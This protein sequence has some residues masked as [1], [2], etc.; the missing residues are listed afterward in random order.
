MWDTCYYLHF[1]DKKINAQGQIH[2]SLSGR[3]GPETTICLS[4]NPAFSEKHSPFCPQAAWS[5]LSPLYAF[6]PLL[7]VKVIL[8]KHY[9]LCGQPLHFIRRSQVCDGQQDCA[10]G[11]D[12]Q[13]CVQNSPDGPPVAGESRAWGAR[14][15]GTA[16]SQLRFPWSTA[17]HLPPDLSV[18][19]PITRFLRIGPHLVH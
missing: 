2:Q 10:S 1:T 9:F 15:V 13:H 3:T 18:S 5:A 19:I 8:D 17:Q 11:E 6:L 14:A 4:P 12:E 7:A 16:G